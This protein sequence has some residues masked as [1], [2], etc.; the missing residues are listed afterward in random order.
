MFRLTEAEWDEHMRSQIV[1]GYPE[2]DP[3][4]A[5]YS[6][7]QAS[8]NWSQFV[9]SSDPLQM[10]ANQ[11][12]KNSSQNVM[13]SKRNRGNVYLP[14]AF[15][16]HGVTMLASVLKSEKAVRM[17]IAVVRAFIALKQLVLQRNSIPA[18]LQE[19][20]DRLGELA[21]IY[22]DYAIILRGDERAAYRAIVNVLD[23][24]R[25]AGI[26]N[27]AFATDKVE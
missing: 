23:I 12:T 24:C 17:S 2:K 18:Q 19:L 10:I 4:G 27:V 22:P 15:T 20:R 9:T 8:A 1:T 7:D 6:D 25:D 14:Y 11:S 16:E 21:R 5:Q 3:G 13:S 26:W